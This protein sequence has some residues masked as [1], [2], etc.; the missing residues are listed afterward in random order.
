MGDADVLDPGQRN[1]AED[2]SD[3][4]PPLRFR[5]HRRC[6]VMPYRSRGKYDKEMGVFDAS[7]ACIPES[8]LRRAYLGQSESTVGRPTDFG[9][10]STRHEGPA[11]YLGP[12]LDNFGHFLLESLARAWLAEQHPETPLVWSREV[13]KT[14]P[15]KSWQKDI[16]DLLGVRNP[17]ICV[18]APA[19]FE[20]LII[21]D[22]GYKIQT[23][24][25]P[26]HADFL[27]RVPHEPLPGRKLWLS[28]SKLD[29]LQNE[30]MPAVES[31]LA[32]LGWTIVHPEELPIREQL[33]HIA[34][35]ERIAAEQGSALHSLI[36]LA[37][38]KNLRLDFFL[39]NPKEKE[40]LYNRNYDT[41][42]E[43]KGIL[44]NVYRIQ[45]EIVRDRKGKN[46]QKYSTNVMEYLEKLDEQPTSRM[47]DEKAPE[48]RKRQASAARINRLASIRSATR[49]LEIGVAGGK[50]F[51]EVDIGTKHAVDPQFRFDTD[52]HETETVRFFP[53]TSDAYFTGE[54][55]AGLR[56]DI[57]FLDGLHTFEQTLRDFCA[58]MPHSHQDT[59]WIIDDV[60]PSDIFSALPSQ[61][62][63]NALRKVHGQ[64]GRSWNGDVYKCIFAIHDFF[65]NFSFRTFEPG[66]GRPQTVVVN[67]PRPDFAP[68]FNDLE[69][70]RGSTTAVPR[71]A[72]TPAPVLI[73]P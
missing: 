21:P 9:P 50:T 66:H 67:R 17:L 20:R 54:A 51:L 8:L 69:K 72:M 40:G 63:A 36:F 25:H 38:P 52:P 53:V 48:R 57:I 28:R 42:A 2:A 10:A 16:L 58:T 32:D 61:E 65:P 14:G 30:S 33:A 46:F 35:A 26:A 4:F 71:E 19:R 12:L 39:R 15:L 64:S 13:G 6:T 60:F 18:E 62:E 3:P 29:T 59:V 31:R 45:S 7:G 49:Y 73:D 68:R 27:A 37:R 22:V 44:Q 56:F 70:S 5:E 23:Y 55:P 24:F 43:R 11:I 47:E 41:I 34:S 1:P